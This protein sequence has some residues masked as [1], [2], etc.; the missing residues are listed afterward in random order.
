MFEDDQNG[1][2]M[3]DSERLLVAMNVQAASLGYRRRVSPRI[4]SLLSHIH[5]PGLLRAQR[6]KA[7]IRDLTG[8]SDS[9]I[10]DQMDAL[11]KDGRLAEFMSHTRKA[12]ESNPHVLLAYSWV[13]YMALF[14]GGRYLRAALADAGGEGLAFWNGEPSTVY[15]GTGEDAKQPN[16]SVTSEADVHAGDRSSAQS[17]SRFERGVSMSN[18]GLQFFNFD[19]DR[20]GEDIKFEFKKRVVEVEILLTNGEKENIIAEAEHIFNFMIEVVLELDRAIGC[21]PP[22]GTLPSE[23]G[24]LEYSKQDNVDTWGKNPVKMPPSRHYSEGGLAQSLPGSA[25]D[26]KHLGSAWTKWLTSLLLFIALTSWYYG[27]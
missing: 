6:V 14:S 5:L 7:D 12:I 3:Q 20:D 16:R 23:E 8:M 19:G 13:F 18:L 25:K 10:E 1:V 9:V 27:T 2:L 24:A 11:S 22:I 21:P 4:H 15:C 26:A 17:W